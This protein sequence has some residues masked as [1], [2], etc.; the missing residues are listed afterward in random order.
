MRRV[1]RVELLATCALAAG[2]WR[3][4]VLRSDK[5]LKVEGLGLKVGWKL[6]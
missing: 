4:W 2:G 3:L 6:Y 5:G 1:K